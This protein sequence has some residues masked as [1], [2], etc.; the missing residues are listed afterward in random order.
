MLKDK[1]RLL[2]EQEVE[3]FVQTQAEK[4]LKFE[5]DPMGYILQKYPSL[6]AT[7]SDL[8]TDSYKD[9][10]T[11]VFV[12]A[13]I[14]TT[15]KILLHNGQYFF[16]I[17]AKDSYIAKIAGKKYYLNDLGAEEYAIKSIADLLTMGS[18]PGA[19]GPDT[20]TE[21]ETVTD[22]GEED[23]TVEPPAEDEGGGEE[24]QL[25]E[26]TPTK[27]RIIKEHLLTEEEKSLKQQIIDLL[28]DGDFDD[29]QLTNIRNSIA[30]V[31][32]RKEY[33]TY[34]DDKGL[35]TR[36]KDDIFNKSLQLG[37]IQDLMDYIGSDKPNFTSLPTSGNI[38]DIEKFKK[39][40]EEFLLWLYQYTIGATEKVVGVGKME[41][42]LTL[43]LDDTKNPE[44]GDVGL[45]SG[46][47]IEVK[48]NDA[49]IWGQKDGILSTS[50]FKI[51]SKSIQ[52]HFGDLVKEPYLGEAGSATAIHPILIRN[53]AEAIKAGASKEKAL[54][55]IKK[56]LKDFYNT[57]QTAKFIDD[58][59]KLDSIK[60]STTLQKQIFKAQL[61]AYSD[62]EGWTYLWIGDPKNGN[63]RIFKKEE[64]DS[65]VDKGEIKISSSMGL[66]NVYRAIVSGF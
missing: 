27:F 16:L 41:E 5:D 11:G 42:F 25:A 44:K 43:M 24:D 1:L 45:D 6:D 26:N 4:I 13:P 46:E 49:K 57:P 50:G 38:K 28:K 9:Y 55:A 22:T 63:Y 33:N 48:G 47:E 8:L 65:A 10:I 29:E 2:V 12:M 54:E 37:I 32:Y 14:P 34:V 21:N 3:D 52:T 39:L 17:Y 61:N 18:P 58:Y 62:V 31:E 35:N 36:A 56:V 53:A 30:G 7:L 64:L 66:N 51:G 20:E 60:D 19:E 40:P 23:T 59:I 15:F